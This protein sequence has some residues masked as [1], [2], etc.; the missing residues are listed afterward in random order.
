[1]CQEKNGYT[2]CTRDL[3]Q[4]FELVDKTKILEIVFVQKKERHIRVLYRGGEK[5]SPIFKQVTCFSYFK[6]KFN[7][8]LSFAKNMIYK[9]CSGWARP[10]LKKAYLRFDSFRKWALIFCSSPFLC[11]YIFSKPFHFRRAFGSD[12]KTKICKCIQSY[13]II[14]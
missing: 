8:M 13:Q 1:M 12:E 2:N 7:K 3:T 6:S 9:Y 4:E 14:K 5:G 11:L 10:R